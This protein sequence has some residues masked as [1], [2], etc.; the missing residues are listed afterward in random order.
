MELP[1]NAALCAV[2]AHSHPAKRAAMVKFA[3]AAT[4]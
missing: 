3:I 1:L 4:R 2:S